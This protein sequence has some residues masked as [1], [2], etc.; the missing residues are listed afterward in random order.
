MPSQPTGWWWWWGVLKV[1]FFSPKKMSGNNLNGLKHGKPAK[2]VPIFF[3]GHE[4]SSNHYF[5]REYV[6]FQGVNGYVCYVFLVCWVCLF[7]LFRQFCN[8]PC[9]RIYCRETVGWSQLRDL[10]WLHLLFFDID[11]YY[12]YQL[13]SRLSFLAYRQNSRILEVQLLWS[14]THFGKSKAPTPSWQIG[15]QVPMAARSRSIIIEGVKRVSPR[16]TIPYGFEARIQTPSQPPPVG[17][18][19][20]WFGSVG[21]FRCKGNFLFIAVSPSDNWKQKKQQQKAELGNCHSFLQ[22]WGWWR[23]E[24]IYIYRIR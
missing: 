15:P 9:L 20:G 17:Q 19:V 11:V 24:N 16:S 8:T 14:S 5:F 22:V 10:S 3:K 4:S 13:R 21:F 2:K 23:F 18:P 1:G 12:P 6:R 7:F